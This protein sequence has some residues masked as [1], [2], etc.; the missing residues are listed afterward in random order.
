MK[1]LHPSGVSLYPLSGKWTFSIHVQNKNKLQDTQ[2]KNYNM[3]SAVTAAVGLR[4]AFEHLRY[5]SSV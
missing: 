4:P 3:K 5:H 2:M 1:F